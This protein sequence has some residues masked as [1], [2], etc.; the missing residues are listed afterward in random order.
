[1]HFWLTK[2]LI[3][4]PE[5]ENLRVLQIRFRSETNGTTEQF[6]RVFVLIFKRQEQKETEG[7]EK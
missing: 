5:I 6:C 3:D 7:N 2:W 4:N 1:M